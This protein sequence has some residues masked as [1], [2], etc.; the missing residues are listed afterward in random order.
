MARVTETHLAVGRTLRL[1]LAEIQIRVSR[2]SGPGG[3]H[4]N[5]TATRVEAVFDAAASDA[6]GPV[7]RRRI[8]SR[9]GGLVSAVA[10]DSRS[11]SRNRELA[12]LRLGAKLEDAL[13]TRRSRIATKPT[14][15]ANERRLAD[16]RATAERKSQRRPPSL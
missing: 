14:R 3:Q 9:T 1:P 4:A 15:S 16:K 12:L 7:Q 8:V 10:Q 6:L 5:K 11:Q 13:A 2:S